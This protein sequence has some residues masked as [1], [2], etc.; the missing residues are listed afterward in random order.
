[1]CREHNALLETW[2]I[3]IETE[4]RLI[5]NKGLQAGA[6]GNSASVIAACEGDSD[7]IPTN[8][9][10]AGVASLRRGTSSIQLEQCKIRKVP[11]NALV[12]G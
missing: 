4:L 2:Y 11:D 3:K 6:W 9:S 12:D 7:E 1:M 5:L 10:G 8:A